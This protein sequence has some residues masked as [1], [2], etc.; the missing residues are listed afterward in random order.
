MIQS[1]VVLEYSVSFQ[2]DLSDSI[3]Q[4]PLPRI[5]NMLSG[6]NPTL[7]TILITGDLNS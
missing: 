4:F 1:H 5:S 3:L 7:C 2:L 6:S